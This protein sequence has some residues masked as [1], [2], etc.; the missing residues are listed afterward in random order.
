MTSPLREVLAR[1]GISADTSQLD[2]ADKKVSSTARSLRGLV[3]A[4][5]GA[6]TLYAFGR[7]MTSTI[8]IGDELATSAERI[9]MTTRDLQ[10]FRHAA[11]MA[12]VPVEQLQQG[13]GLLS[14]KIQDADSGEGRALFARLGVSTRDA[15]GHVRGLSEMLPEIAEGFRL[16]IPQSERA[17]VA[18][19]LFGRSGTA[20]VPML[21]RGRAGLED[22]R[23][24]LDRLGGGATAEFIAQASAA[25]DEMNRLR[26]A[27]T[28]LRT[29]LATGLLPTLTSVVRWLVR[30]TAALSTT[31][32]AA[33]VAKP[34]A[35]ALGVAVAAAGVNAAIAWGAAVGPILLYAA[36]A[37]ALYLILDELVGI[38]NGSATATEELIAAFTGVERAREIMVSLRDAITAVGDAIVGTAVELGRML[39]LVPDD[40][41][42]TVGV[43]GRGVTNVRGVPA[44]PQ[45]GAA[46]ARARAAARAQVERAAGSSPLPIRVAQQDRLATPVRDLMAPSRTPIAGANVFATPT[47]PP[48]RNVTVNDSHRTEVHVH[49]AENP[50]ATARVVRTEMDRREAARNRAVLAAIE[51]ARGGS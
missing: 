3:A 5:G 26:L 22:M 23:A 48:A 29:G 2:K 11:T 27:T 15:R 25:D 30:T 47:T 32:L 44:G 51:P 4:A 39:G 42:E 28:S 10:A 20:M 50:E 34:L 35:V 16:H 24:E 7:F 13:L 9:G 31:G 12:D 6:A 45:T 17:A 8:A 19:D 40:M 49:A 18:M 21:S 36:G 43:T 14:R 1:F 46:D 37:A 33:K 41:A 38:Q